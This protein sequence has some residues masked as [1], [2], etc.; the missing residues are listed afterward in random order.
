MKL[1]ISNIAWGVEQD[2]AVFRLMKQQGFT[3]LEIAP[4][5]IFP[6]RP[7][8]RIKEAQK[9]A[10]E[11]KA[12][13][14]FTMPS[15]QSIWYGRRENI[16]ASVEERN[17]LE[18]YTRDAID[19]AAAIGCRNL[20]FGGP[21]NRIVPDKV[22]P[23]DADRI[24][25]PFFRKIGAYAATRGIVIGMEANPEIYGTNFINRTSEA[26]CLVQEIN[27]EGFRLNLDVGTMIQN[28]ERVEEVVGNVDLISHVHISEPGLGL[29]KERTLHRQ[30]FELLRNEGYKGYVSI[31]M[32]K[33]EDISELE[34]VMRY[35]KGIFGDR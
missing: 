4:T 17:A 28:E 7:Y 22:S 23:G 31:E 29:V 30:L 6:D 24:A 1:A 27:S 2:E 34:R 26:I 11:L 32:G 20:V 33:R 18:K 35:M 19:F 21:K 5:R 14:G 3:G 25:V 16:F 13:Y 9:W 15:M 8:D 12:K 10:E